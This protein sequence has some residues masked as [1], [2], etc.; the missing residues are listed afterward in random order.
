MGALIAILLLLCGPVYATGYSG[1]D[2]HELHT[3]DERVVSEEELASAVIL[4]TTAHIQDGTFD[5]DGVSGDIYFY[6]YGDA[7]NSYTRVGQTLIWQILQ[8][9]EATPIPNSAFT[10]DGL[11]DTSF[12][13]KFDQALPYWNAGAGVWDVTP[14]ASAGGGGAL[15]T[16]T[17]QQFAVPGGTPRAGKVFTVDGGTDITAVWSEPGSEFGVTLN[18]DPTPTPTDTPVPTS[19]P[20]PIAMEITPSGVLTAVPVGTNRYAMGVDA[21]SVQGATKFFD[22]TDVQDISTP[23]PGN[24]IMISASLTPALVQVSPV[25]TPIVP[26]AIVQYVTKITV[27][28]VDID[29]DTT[30]IQGAN[31][32]ILATAATNSIEFISQSGGTPVP[33]PT[34]TPQ[35]LEGLSNVIIDTNLPVEGERLALIYDDSENEW[36]YKTQTP[37]PTFT[38]VPA[39]TPTFTPIELLDIRNVS[40]ATPSAG[41][42]L[43]WAGGE[44]APASISGSVKSLDDLSDVSTSGEAANDLLVFSGVQWV[45]ATFTPTHTPT[46]TPTPTG[47]STPRTHLK[48]GSSSNY[49]NPSSVDIPGATIAFTDAGGG[50]LAFDQDTGLIETNDLMVLRMDRDHDLDPPGSEDWEFRMT[51]WEGT[52]EEYELFDIVPDGHGGR[53]RIFTEFSVFDYSSWKKV[54]VA[55]SDAL[56][57]LNVDDGKVDFKTDEL[58]IAC[59][60]SNVAFAFGTLGLQIDNSSGSEF[61]YLDAIDNMVHL[62]EASPSGLPASGYVAIYVA[63][64]SPAVG[65]S[66]GPDVRVLTAGGLEWRLNFSLV[67]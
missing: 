10:F 1:D 56:R 67:P 2:V 36:V 58:G 45:N 41:Q 66:Y 42:F 15:P 40:T 22:L 27:G 31:M 53:F 28:A 62:V 26:A 39:A 6:L 38:S 20:T 54:S 59:L 21:A 4:Y 5:P 3:L 30:F 16:P 11:G 50:A 9:A 49:T 12:G 29:G 64:A 32:V 25:P 48:K 61:L 43:G 7:V 37:T 14:Q 55:P 51:E 18:L 33:V 60:T 13:A 46:Q 63:D 24:F 65:A 19:T 8:R 57:T 17:P 52:D 47:T 23:T 35:P 44:W 34:V